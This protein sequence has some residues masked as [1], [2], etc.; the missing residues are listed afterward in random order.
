MAKIKA[1]GKSSKNW[2]KLH[3]HVKRLTDPQQPVTVKKM[4]NA[5]QQVYD[6]ARIRVELET[7]EPLTHVPELKDLDIGGFGGTPGPACE[8]VTAEQKQLAGFRKNV[9][10]GE[11]VIYI[12]RSL[13]NANAG[14]AAHPEDKPMAALSALHADIYTMAHEVGHLL[15]LPHTTVQGK[16]RLMT[17]MGTRTLTS[18]PPPVLIAAEINDMRKSPFLK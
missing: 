14:C 13:T 3:I 18:N 12:C 15:G 16:N 2:K 8:K 1:N 4:V 6:A 17:N 11:I 7:N 9:P 10:D 5:M